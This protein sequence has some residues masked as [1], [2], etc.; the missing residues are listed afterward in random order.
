MNGKQD[1]M[2]GHIDRRREAPATKAARSARAMFLRMQARRTVA[3]MITDL[4]PNEQA[5]ILCD[6]LDMVAEQLHPR[7][8]RVEAATAF[9]SRAADICGPLKLSRAIASARAEQLFGPKPA[10]DRGTE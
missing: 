10:N 6:A 9:N 4:E 1:W 7:I 3:E 2:A 5:T 8:G